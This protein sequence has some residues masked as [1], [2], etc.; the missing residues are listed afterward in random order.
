MSEEEKEEEEKNQ[1]Q[2]HGQDAINCKLRNLVRYA[3]YI[4]VVGGRDGI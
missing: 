3:F 1:K 2:E 4:E